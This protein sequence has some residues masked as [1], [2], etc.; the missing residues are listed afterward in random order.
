MNNFNAKKFN[1]ERSCTDIPF[2]IIFLAF[3]GSMIYLTSLGLKKG[4]INK[5]LSPLDGDKKFCGLNNQLPEGETD[6]SFVA[7]DYSDYPK[8]MLTDLSSPNVLN[9][10]SKGVCVKECPSAGQPAPECMTTTE[11]TSCPENGSFLVNT[12][13]VMGICIPSSIEDIQGG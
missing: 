2:L 11:V 12:K 5:L 1:R 4:D 6:D 8:L 9:I 13:S 3:L 7:Y 10:F